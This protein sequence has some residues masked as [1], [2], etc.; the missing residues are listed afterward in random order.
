VGTGEGKG[1]GK[2]KG[3]P[4]RKDTY[5]SGQGS[6]SAVDMPVWVSVSDI[7]DIY[8]FII[9]IFLVLL[10]RG[11]L[12]VIRFSLEYG[13]SIPDPCTKPIYCTGGMQ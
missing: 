9:V 3:Q 12:V 10:G 7:Y 8:I 11:V 1:E 4:L 13:Y 5:S 2:G 6:L